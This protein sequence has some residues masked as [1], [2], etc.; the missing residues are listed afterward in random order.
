[1]YLAAIAAN[2]YK[3]TNI[4]LP[5]YKAKRQRMLTQF[6]ICTELRGGIFHSCKHI[7]SGIFAIFAFSACH[8]ETHR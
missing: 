6:L 7:E 4:L 5:T 1:M 2:G 8:G 3:R